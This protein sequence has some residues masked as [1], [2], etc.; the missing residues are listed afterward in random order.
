MGKNKKLA[1]KKKPPQ[2][3]KSK[4]TSKTLQSKTSAKSRSQKHFQNQVAKRKLFQK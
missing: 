2:I 3:P 4:K 1:E